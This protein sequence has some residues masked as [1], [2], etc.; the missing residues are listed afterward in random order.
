MK[1][2]KGGYKSEFIKSKVIT[3]ILWYPWELVPNSL[4]IL[5]STDSHAYNL[6]NPPIYLNHVY[7]THDTQ[8]YGNAM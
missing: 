2:S 5:K 3:A 1:P 4:H 6:C 7:V 8:C